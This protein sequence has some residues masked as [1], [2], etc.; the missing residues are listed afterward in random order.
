MSTLYGRGA[1]GGACV[2][3]LVAVLVPRR[4]RKGRRE[5][6]CR[7][8]GLPPRPRGGQRGRGAAHRLRRDR[9]RALALRVAS[10]PALHGLRREKEARGRHLGERDE[11]CPV[12]TER[13]TTHVHFV[14]EGGGGGGRRADGTTRAAPPARMGYSRA[15]TATRAEST[16]PDAITG[17]KVCPA[18]EGHAMVGGF[19]AEYPAPGRVIT[20]WI[21]EPPRVLHEA[22]KPDP[23]QPPVQVTVADPSVYAVV[24][25]PPIVTDVIDD[26]CVV[27]RAPCISSIAVAGTCS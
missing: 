24:C 12:S 25:A 27:F 11:T 2:R 4:D 16:A 9:E 10:L 22:A 19:A 7:E 1:G 23:V 6:Y 3:G 15:P 17:A 18:P 14:R 20:R 21:T 13:W 5:A 8:R 26:V